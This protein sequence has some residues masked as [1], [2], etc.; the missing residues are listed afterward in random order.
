[1]PTWGLTPEMRKSKPWGLP[2]ELLRPAKKQ[3][4]P[5]H[6]DIYWTRLEQRLIDSRPFQ[7]LRHIK[8][9]GMTLKVYPGAEHSRFT[10]CLGTLRTAQD[11]LDRTLDNLSG[12]HAIPSLFHEWSMPELG[13]SPERYVLCLAEATVLTRLSAL[14]HDLTHVPFGHTIEDDLSVLT[15]HDANEVRFDRLFSEFPDDVRQ[16]LEAARTRAPRDG[17]ESSLL[18]AVRSIVLDKVDGAEA[19]GDGAPNPTDA[20]ALYP[21]VGDI[22]NNTISADLLDYLPRDHKFTGLPIAVGDRF[23]D[24]FYVPP[25]SANTDYR[26]RLVLRISR[27]GEESADVITELLK[28]LRFRYEE[29]ER[30][31]FHKTKLAYDA[32]LGKLLEMWRDSLWYDR[33][34]SSHPDLS[35]DA[36]ALDADWIRE[37]VDARSAG[38]HDAPTPSQIDDAVRDTMEDRFLFFGDEGLIEN[39]IWELSTLEEKLGE[40]K[41]EL[42][43]RRAGI[44]QLAQQIRY[45]EHFR[46]LGHVGGPKV[47]PVAKE[48]FKQYG[49][50][51]ARRR[52]ERDVAR[53]VQIDPAWQV[54]LWVP[55]PNMRLKVADVLVDD[56]R[57]ISTLAS[58]RP[59]AEEI[60]NRHRALWS[61]RVYA[62]ADIR[63]NPAQRL[64]ILAFLRD[65]MNLQF[66]GWDGAQV[67]TS[68]R[69]AAE[70][71]GD[72]RRLRSHEIAELETH[73]TAAR[74][75]SATFADLLERTSAV[76]DEL[77][78]PAPA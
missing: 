43:G 5:V 16:A 27:E 9:L 76:A 53:W 63:D 28:Y 25:T 38:E 75:E 52:L 46:M 29:A 58:M 49:N 14:L 35:D 3:T 45:R 40:E 39:L 34:V 11:M 30:A 64:Q 60:V 7:R 50:A 44:R 71:E 2:D 13:G 56:E 51:E 74:A 54:V 31:L 47:I 6:G 37:Q 19:H 59:E 65:E 23:M 32:M 41:K 36:R 33:A 22:V 67:P 78:Y 18:A 77:G 61:I 24:D 48:K 57:I 55:N 66:V 21:F 26:E 73:I 1:M 42:D 10:H 72:A 17:K 4:D 62:P 8:Q 70:T 12:P 68:N 69:L 15:P 20:R